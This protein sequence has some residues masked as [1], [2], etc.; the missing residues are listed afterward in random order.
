MSVYLVVVEVVHEDLHDTGEYH[1][2]GA[3][4]EEFV[5]VVKWLILLWFGSWHKLQ[6]GMSGSDLIA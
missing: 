6:D 3:G 1:H 2:T 5:D 4:D